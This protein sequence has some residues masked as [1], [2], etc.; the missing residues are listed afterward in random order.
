MPNLQL[1]LVSQ[2]DLFRI[3]SCIWITS[4]LTGKKMPW[5]M[6]MAAMLS[7]CLSRPQEREG[8][9]WRDSTETRGA[10]CMEGELPRLPSFALGCP[11]CRQLKGTHG[12]TGPT[13]ALGKNTGPGPSGGP[14]NAPILSGMFQEI[15]FFLGRLNSCS[16]N[17]SL[18]TLSYFI[19]W[20]K[21]LKKSRAIRHLW[22]ACLVYLTHH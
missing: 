9:P 19:T 2:G 8:A 10:E 3:L 13:Q 7:I 21:I 14:G 16:W 22:K 18:H 15:S 1:V 20:E 12:R 5:L 11:C 6:V 17:S 4:G